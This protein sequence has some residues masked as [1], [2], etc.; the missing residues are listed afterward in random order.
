MVGAKELKKQKESAL[1]KTSL[2]MQRTP[3]FQTFIFSEF[4]PHTN[5]RN[6][7]SSG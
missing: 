7:P 5:K 6:I 3:K 1:A 4:I 2:I